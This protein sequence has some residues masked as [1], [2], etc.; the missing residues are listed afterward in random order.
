MLVSPGVDCVSVDVVWA[1]LVEEKMVDVVAADVAVKVMVDVVVCAVDDVV[2]RE[3][4]VS[5]IKGD[6]NGIPLLRLI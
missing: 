3:G 6:G 1:L 5:G 2:V 4:G